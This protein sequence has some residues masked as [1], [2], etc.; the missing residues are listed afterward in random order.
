MSND[1][2]A[3]LQRGT[4]KLSADAGNATN[5]ER[6]AEQL[7]EVL[8]AAQRE[9]GDAAVCAALDLLASGSGRNVFRHAAAIVRGAKSG[10]PMIDDR[11]ALQRIAQYPET[12]RSEA[13]GKVARQVAGPEASPKSIATIARRLRDKIKRRKL[14]SPSPAARMP[15]E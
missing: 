12:R 11:A 6:V 5:H 1:R 14:I 15:G 2:P 8:L 7:Y 4:E 3:R 13:V 9:A 10:R